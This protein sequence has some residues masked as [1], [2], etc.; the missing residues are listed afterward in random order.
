MKV[1][2]ITNEPIDSEDYTYPDL[3]PGNV[4]NV[5]EA[6]S[7]SYRLI[8]DEGK[9]YLYDFRRFEI[10]E[11]EVDEDYV[12]KF[13]EEGHTTFHPPLLVNYVY[14]FEDYFNHV[15]KVIITFDQ[16]M[17]HKFEKKLGKL[18]GHITHPNKYT[19]DKKP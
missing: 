5:I 9:P 2:C 8:G 1:R 3:T 6:T 7:C 14:F 18:E 19:G 13:D 17:L 16:Y 15:S 11:N 4:Y 12:A 10:I